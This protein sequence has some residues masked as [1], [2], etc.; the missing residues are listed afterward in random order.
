[1]AA[2]W[3]VM[4]FKT[5]RLSSLDVNKLSKSSTCASISSS[6]AEAAGQ[7]G[8]EP[9]LT[10]CALS[11]CFL[12]VCNVDAGNFKHIQWNSLENDHPR[13]E[14]LQGDGMRHKALPWQLAANLNG[15]ASQEQF[16]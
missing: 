3:V 9:G 10:T 2:I 8:Q 13:V 16:A 14:E 7:P 5:F 6:A 15:P 11:I 1:M 4:E 12:T